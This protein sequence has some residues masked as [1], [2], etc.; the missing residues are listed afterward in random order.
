MSS[1]FSRIISGELPAHKI[2]EVENY[3]AFL[4]I[5]P[6]MPGHTLVV[7]KR[8]IENILDL[9]DELYVGL[10][11]FAKQVAKAV[12]HVV[13]CQRVGFV[14]AG[15]EVPHVHIHIIPMNATE[16]LNFA[17]QRERATD[18]ELQ[19]LAEEIRQALQTFF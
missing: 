17:K 6:L 5:Y 13:A 12:Q 4:D 3:L 2:V 15:F 16:D 1:I 9:D 8:E 19:K 10:W 7:P 14:V 11:I 18:E